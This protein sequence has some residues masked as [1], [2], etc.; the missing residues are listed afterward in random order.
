MVAAGSYVSEQG[1]LESW[2][3]VLP[4]KLLLAED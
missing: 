3:L 4:T 1:R 2:A